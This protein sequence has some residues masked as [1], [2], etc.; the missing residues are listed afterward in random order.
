MEIGVPLEDGRE[1]RLNDRISITP[2]IVPHRDEY[3]ETVAFIIKGPTRSVLWL[4]DI[5][6]QPDRALIDR[7]DVAYIDGTFFDEKEL[8]GRSRAEIPHPM[9]VDSMKQYS[10]EKVRFIHLNQSNP[11]LRNPALV[12]PFHVARERERTRL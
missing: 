6:K 3:S 7:V 9:I 11:A 5:D 4:P 1:V 10:P 8:P 12:K 2:V